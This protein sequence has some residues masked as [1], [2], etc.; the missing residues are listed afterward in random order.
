MAKTVNEL[1]FNTKQEN[2]TQEESRTKQ[3]I[4]IEYLLAQG[5]SR[6]NLEMKTDLAARAIKAIAK[7]KMHSVIFGDSI[8]S[9]L[10]D[11]VMTLNISKDR[12]GRKELTDL[13]KMLANENEDE[14]NR[15]IL[16]RLAG[17]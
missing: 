1:L 11:T 16:Q 15:N 12:K 4:K 7:G 8:L 10:C 5:F 17:G 2:N 13:T 9:D 6:D 14:N 3:E